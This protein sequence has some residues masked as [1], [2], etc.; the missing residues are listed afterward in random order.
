MNPFKSMLALAKSSRDSAE[1]RLVRE[2]SIRC[3]IK[4]NV[5]TQESKLNSQHI[6]ETNC[7]WHDNETSFN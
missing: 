5:E 3:S 2:W 6:L 1:F 7:F 4:K